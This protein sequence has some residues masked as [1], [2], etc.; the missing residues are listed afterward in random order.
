MTKTPVIY[1]KD[2]I[3]YLENYQGYTFIHCDCYRWNRKI[4]TRL[5]KDIDILVSIH[6]APIY[7]F[8]DIEDKK[9]FKFLNMFK[10]K[11]NSEIPC[12]DGKVRQL[13]VRG[14]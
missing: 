2:Y 12:S 8:H 3:V 14:L 13:F 4:K 7:A 1:N 11:H 9:H 6:N 5:Q 10:F